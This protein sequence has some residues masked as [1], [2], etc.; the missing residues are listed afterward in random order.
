MDW[1]AENF[2]Y[3]WAAIFALVSVPFMLLCLVRPLVWLV[4]LVPIFRKRL[5]PAAE[6]MARWS[7]G[8]LQVGAPV[9]VSAVFIPVLI[10]AV[11]VVV[12]TYLLMKW[13]VPAKSEAHGHEHDAVPWWP[14]FKTMD[15]PLRV[16][17]VTA[18]AQL[19][20][21][22]AILWALKLPATP[23]VVGTLHGHAIQIDQL[24]I[25]T[26]SVFL[27]IGFGLALAGTWASTTGRFI[28]LA[29]FVATSRP[30]D[31]HG[32]PAMIWS[33]FVGVLTVAAVLPLLW[34]GP[35]PAREP[36]DI[37]TDG[38]ALAG[39]FLAF[40]FF[41]GCAADSCSVTGW[42]TSAA[43]YPAF[44]TRQF[45]ELA[46]AIT[47]VLF[48]AGTDFAEVGEECGRLVSKVTRK[49]GE[50]GIAAI[51][52][53]CVAVASIA[54]VFMLKEIDF[55]GIKMAALAVTVLFSFVL[56]A[57]L[58]FMA[59]ARWS[60]LGCVLSVSL[61]VTNIAILIFAVWTGGWLIVSLLAIF[62]VG[63]AIAVLGEQI[64]LG[65]WSSFHISFAA[66]AVMA[67]V[68]AGSRETVSLVSAWY[69]VP[70]EHGPVRFKVQQ[71]EAPMGSMALLESWT[72]DPRSRPG[73]YRFSAGD[74]YEHGSLA[75][76]GLDLADAQARKI[77]PRNLVGV[78]WPE[79]TD[80]KLGPEDDIGLGK[81]PWSYSYGTIYID[82]RRYA[83]T[84]FD[85]VE[86][87][88]WWIAVSVGAA[89]YDRY[90]TGLVGLMLSTWRP[91]LSAMAPEEVDAVDLSR[92]ATQVGG[93]GF[94][95]ILFAPVGLFLLVGSFWRQD[96]NGSFDLRTPTGTP[97]EMA[98]LLAI[99]VAVTAMFFLPET[100]LIE[101]WRPAETRKN[102]LASLQLVT[103]GATVVV[104]II[105]WLRRRIQAWAEMLHELSTLNI[106]ILFLL[107]VYSIYGAIIPLGHHHVTVEA[108][109]LVAALLWDFLRSGKEI[110]N[111]D[112]PVLRRPARILVYL[113][114]I[115]LV[116]TT[117]LFVS[118]QTAG[119]GEAPVEKVLESEDVVR[120]GII[121]LGT[122]LLLL[123]FLLRFLAWRVREAPMRPPQ[124]APRPPA[125]SP[126]GATSP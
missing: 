16:I 101:F 58:A 106:G 9:F 117:V 111:T 10:V 35:D 59:E 110:T 107:I 124:P 95:P 48:L 118:A 122:P 55:T 42:T 80:V 88:N 46:I 115:A 14:S 121:W 90:Y 63:A 81:R 92:R 22:A 44:L 51:V 26:T 43:N 94:L 114:Y 67:L 109:M 69:A 103:A 33:V 74:D 41:T 85:L 73:L 38:L 6:M 3:G 79:L 104:V 112:G 23:V 125:A 17:T 78:F 105:A 96:K 61:I 86:G 13:F 39:T 87:Q 40:Y 99:A 98:G 15:W 18:I 70:V 34:R 57:T 77:R 25:I 20:A 12:A 37:V 62:F 65:K 31:W 45:G 21:S 49:I 89:R 119:T 123:R 108:G 1:L 56:L 76:A 32:A 91:D 47:P 54:A 113:G 24:V 102:P 27:A 82:G 66:V 75:I 8:L 120:Q 5:E 64:G 28:V 116:G 36:T 7:D 97:I 19:L 53:V 4:R 126:W 50:G 84:V 93:F 30:M 100:E 11:P 60:S 29:L 52:A 2:L 71:F 68:M 72:I 83:V